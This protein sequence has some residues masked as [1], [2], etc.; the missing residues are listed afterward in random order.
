MW[1]EV[2][3]NCTH[4]LTLGGALDCGCGAMNPASCQ[5]NGFINIVKNA[6]VSKFIIEN[7]EN[8][9]VN[10][11]LHTCDCSG[12]YDSVEVGDVWYLVENGNATKIMK[13][14]YSGGIGGGVGTATVGGKELPMFSVWHEIY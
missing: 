7:N 13:P 8:C 10:E 5:P 6:D 2:C 3:Q 11:H 9:V 12:H 4:P 1:L 14:K